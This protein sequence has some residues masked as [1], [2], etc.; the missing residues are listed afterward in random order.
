MLGPFKNARDCVD[1]IRFS[2]EIIEYEHKPDTEFTTS[3]IQGLYLQQNLKI[4]REVTPTLAESL[5]IVYDRL[6]MP[7][8]SATAYVY[9]SPEIQAGCFSAQ[10]DHCILFF[11][12]GIVS[13]LDEAELQ[14]VAGHEI[15]HF[16]LSHGHIYREDEL[17]TLDYYVH[18]RA[19]EI[20]ADRVGLSACQSLDCS[21]RAMMKTA[22]GLPSQFLRFDINSFLS[23]LHNH[24]ETIFAITQML[25][26][27]S[28]LV[29]CKAIFWF[30]MS[31]YLSK[32]LD[33]DFKNHLLKI[34]ENIEKDLHRYVDGPFRQTLNDA[35][36]KYSFWLSIDRTTQD[37]RLDKYSQ[38][39]ISE[40]FGGDYLRKFFDL[41][42]NLTELEVREI[43]QAKLVDSKKGLET[44]LPRRFKVVKKGLEKYVDQLFDQ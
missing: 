21:I 1:R 29:R 34:D 24:E 41:V 42:Y 23:Q 4:S 37:G 44:L 30:S 8:D 13:L 35:K 10:S 32:E 25:T 12:S 9:P 27:P 5:G 14:F 3:Q 38:E 6:F 19:K 39:I 22:S 33:N 7:Q 31:E 36:R 11:S 20:S 26:H 28:W 43:V 18:Q 2:G 40:N 17:D 16:L 15:G